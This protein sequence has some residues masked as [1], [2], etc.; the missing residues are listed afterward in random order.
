MKIEHKCRCAECRY[1]SLGE[2]GRWWW[3]TCKAYSHPAIYCP[4]CGYFLADDG[5]AYEMV[6]KDSVAEVE[7]EREWWRENSLVFSHL[8]CRPKYL[9][10]IACSERD[11]ADCQAAYFATEPWNQ[12]ADEGSESD[13]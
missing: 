10:G 1:Y 11:C 6:R 8:Y 13:E 4:R 12:S 5:F 2:G 7:V 3:D 9:E